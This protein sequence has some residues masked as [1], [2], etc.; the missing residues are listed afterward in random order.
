VLVSS[1]RTVEEPI[2]GSSVSETCT[3]S[4]KRHGGGLV[5]KELAMRV[6]AG[7]IEELMRGSIAW[8][9]EIEARRVA[10]HK[11]QRSR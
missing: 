11:S 9:K 2:K 1:D 7:G 8:A 4:T 3:Y 5:P 10:Q 6:T